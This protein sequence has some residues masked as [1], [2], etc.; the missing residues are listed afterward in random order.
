M[1]TKVCFC[2]FFITKCEPSL[3]VWPSLI[4]GVA[5]MTIPLQRPLIEFLI[6]ETSN[7]GRVLQTSGFGFCDWYSSCVFFSQFSHVTVFV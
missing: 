6:T 3:H 1:D 2:L 5:C 7:N 4:H